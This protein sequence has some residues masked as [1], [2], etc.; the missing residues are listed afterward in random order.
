MSIAPSQTAS[1]VVARHGVSW[2][3][4]QALASESS[5]GRLTYDRGTL[6][7]MS[8]SFNHDNVSRTLFYWVKIYAEEA[9]IEIASSGSTTLS[10]TEAQRAIEADESFYFASAD[11]I[12][13][14]ADIDL[15]VDP[16]PDLLI[17]V[18]VTNSSLNKLDICRSLAIPEVWRFKDERIEVY[19]LQDDQ[20]YALHD[21]SS[22]LPDFP[23]GGAI[24][25][26]SQRQ[27]LG[28][29]EMAKRF[30]GLVRDVK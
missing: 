24:D 20:Q 25:L 2:D 23:L 30:R 11:Q 15:S 8:P 13:G 14:N 29:N 22:V 4:F 5:G 3:M 17:E 27:L 21:R 6:E 7:I 28:E 10:S 19:V 26:L 9:G 1:Q 16:P 12:R 18:D